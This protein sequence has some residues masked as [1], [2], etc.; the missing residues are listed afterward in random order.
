MTPVEQEASTV[1]S[2]LVSLAETADRAGANALHSA[3]FAALL[4][5]MDAVGE[6]GLSVDSQALGVMSGVYEG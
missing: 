5:V 2:S 6:D 3:A 4:M 1:L